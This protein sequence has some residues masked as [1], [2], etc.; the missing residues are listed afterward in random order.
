VDDIVGS[1][2][3]RFG[4]A[5]HVVADVVFDQLGHE[6]VDGAAGGGETL[7]DIRAG[8]DYYLQ[9]LIAG[10]KGIPALFMRW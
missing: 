2:F 5:R 8:I 1:L 10:R 9:P 4:I 7:E 6:A 3:R